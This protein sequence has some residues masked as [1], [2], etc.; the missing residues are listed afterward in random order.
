MM[1]HR[2]IAVS[3]AGCLALAFATVPAT[4]QNKS[5]MRGLPKGAK[6]DEPALTRDQLRQ[7]LRLEKELE[8]DGPDVR[9]QQALI[10]AESARIEKLGAELDEWR[11]TA[12]AANQV[13]VDSFNRLVEEQKAIVSAHNAQLPDYNARLARIKAV[14]TEHDSSCARRMYYDKDMDAIKRG[15]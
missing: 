8:T 9:R 11:K 6:T 14:G 7:C 15:K 5:A 2:L 12:D 4:A 3:G 1:F 10:H 13:E